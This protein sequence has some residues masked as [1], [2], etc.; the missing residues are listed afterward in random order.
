MESTTQGKKFKNI[1]NKVGVYVEYSNP[2]LFEKLNSLDDMIAIDFNNGF[3]VVFAPVEKIS[4]IDAYI[5]NKVYE[6]APA[7]YTLTSIS[8]QD[9]AGALV[10][11]NNPYIPLS[12]KGII[13]G[14]VDTRE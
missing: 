11:H 10:Y 2:Q 6:E 5:K 7:I 13:V 14:L 3:G 9:A 1:A 12:G 8:P 4:E